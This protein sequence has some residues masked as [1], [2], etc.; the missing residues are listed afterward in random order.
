M[1]ILKQ[2]TAAK[3]PY[4]M[5]DATDSITGKT[6]LTPTVTLSKD[7]AAFGAAGGSST[8]IGNGWYY[9]SANTTDTNTLGS[10]IV[11]AT[12]TGADAW[13]ESH[14]VAPEVPGMLG[15]PAIQAIWDALTSAL[16]TSGSIGKLLVDN[17]NATIS[18]RSTLT[19][20]NVWDALLSTI[21][22]SSSVGKLIKDNLDAA[23]TTRSTLTAAN[24]WDALLSTISVSSSVGK[25][26]KDNLDAAITTR[27]ADADYTA[28]DNSTIATIASDVTALQTTANDIMAQTDL[29]PPS[30]AS[31]GDCDDA[32]ADVISAFPYGYKKNTAVTG[33]QFRMFDTSGVPA[34]GLTVVVKIS[35]DGGALTTSSNS[36]SELTLGWYTLDITNTEMNAKTVALNFAATG[37]V[38]YGQVITTEE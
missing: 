33:F 29:L 23:I 4:F 5:A 2:S 11:H 13:D 6:G 34:S 9:L 37:A 16:T 25:L 12:A 27:L 22:T 24:V 35:K 20:A 30:P 26:I 21:S 10:L 19:A 3:I 18:S 32:A 28:P 17:V 14:Q 15:A 7:G 1:M 38:S 31:T 36:A 8:E